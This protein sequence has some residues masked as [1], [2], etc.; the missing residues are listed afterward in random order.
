MQLDSKN[1]KN[2]KDN[3]TSEFIRPSWEHVFIY[4][5]IKKR[6]KIGLFIRPSTI[7]EE[8]KKVLRTRGMPHNL[9]YPIIKQMEEEGLIKRINHQ[10]YELTDEQKDE[11]VKEINQKLKDLIEEKYGRRNRMLNAMEECGFIKKAKGTKFLILT[12]DCD[13]KIESMGDFTFW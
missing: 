1:N 13:K 5:K 3:Q 8:L 7:M 4:N 11:R 10:K 6:V 2:K 9:H 12:S